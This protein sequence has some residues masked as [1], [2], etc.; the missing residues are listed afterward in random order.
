MSL[1]AAAA[2]LAETTG[3]GGLAFERIEYGEA[4]AGHSAEDP[5]GIES[6]FNAGDE[7]ASGAVMSQEIPDDSTPLVVPIFSTARIH[8]PS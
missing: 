3:H 8:H 6:L 1:E 7:D 2:A 5:E 4:G